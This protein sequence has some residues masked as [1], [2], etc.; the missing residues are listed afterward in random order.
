MRAGRLRH[1]VTLSRDTGTVADGYGEL[2]PTWTDVVQ[3]YADISPVSL[4]AMKGAKETILG[5]AEVAQ[6]IVA[7]TIYPRDDI[8]TNWRV[9]SGTKIYNIKTIRVN[10]TGS[11]M[12]LICTVGTTG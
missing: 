10:N 5:G 3:I 4:T 9:T 12:T 6:D 7:I 11:D 1:L 8:Q 2:T